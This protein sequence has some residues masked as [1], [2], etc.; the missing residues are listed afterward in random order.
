MT[1][2]RNRRIKLNSDQS[3]REVDVKKEDEVTGNEFC[4]MR[5]AW[6]ISLFIFGIILMTPA[7]YYYSMYLKM[8]HEN[9]YWFSHIK[10]ISALNVEYN[11]NF[12]C[13]GS[14]KR[15]II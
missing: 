11:L 8:L 5:L 12:V 7:S 15:N 3:T 10:V 14:R 6:K 2:L 4:F 9:Y 1:E 13:K